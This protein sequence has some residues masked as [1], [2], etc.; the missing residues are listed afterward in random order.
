MSAIEGLA[1]FLQFANGLIEQAHF[2]E[3]DAEVV[4][5]FGIFVG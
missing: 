4:V 2:A 5:R 1:G 3:G